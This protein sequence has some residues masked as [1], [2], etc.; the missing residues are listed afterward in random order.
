MK[1]ALFAVAAATVLMLC[2]GEPLAGQEASRLQ[3]GLIPRISVGGAFD[4]RNNGRGDAEMYLGL[5]SLE[6]T[7][8][9]TGLALRL[10]GIYAKRDRIDRR[11]TLPETVP[12]IMPFSFFS[13]KVTAAGAMAGVTYDLRRGGDFRPYVLASAGAVK[14]HDRFASGT[15]FICPACTTIAL[16]MVAP[17]LTVRQERP[18]AGAAQFGAGMVYSFP[19]VS[20]LAEARYMTVSYGNTRGLNGAVPVSL[21]LQFGRR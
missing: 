17:A 13:S 3:S 12:G 4:A 6:W 21:G 11:Q 8:N 16:N 18:L 14:T 7:T 15:T 9:V 10:D 20:I 1:R 19:V 5:A 2:R